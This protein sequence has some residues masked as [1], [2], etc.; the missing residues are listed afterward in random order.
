MLRKK[1]ILFPLHASSPS[2]EGGPHMWGRRIFI[3]LGIWIFDF[4]PSCHSLHAS[5]LFS[6][7]VKKLSLTASSLKGLESMIGSKNVVVGG[8]FG[9]VVLVTLF[10][11]CENTCGWKSIVKIRI[12]LF[13]Q[14]KLLFKQCYLTGLGSLTCTSMSISIAKA[15]VIAINFLIK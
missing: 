4:F 1:N 3:C 2:H 6:R 11:Y 7:Q 9:N 15:N 12:V 8:M 13:K 14:R 10:K 5:T